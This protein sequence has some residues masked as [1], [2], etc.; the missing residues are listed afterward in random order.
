M[1]ESE[2]VAAIEGNGGSCRPSTLTAHLQVVER[3]IALMR[4]RLPEPLSL[5]DLAA[6]GIASPFHFNRIFRARTGVPP[7]QFLYALRL[8]EAKRL[9]LTSNRKVTDIC[10]DVGYNSLGSFTT[11]FTKLVG[12]PPT[13]FRRLR[14]A[15]IDLRMCLDQCTG[16]P[17]GMPDHWTV[18]GSIRGHG[19]RAGPVFVGLFPSAIPQGRPLACTV[20]M[21]PSFRLT[22][23]PA[24]R[25]WILAATLCLSPGP[26]A[27][28][29][30]DA[31]ARGRS[32]PVTVSARRGDL[33]ADVEL[34]PPRITDPPILAALPYL[35]LE[36]TARGNRD[37]ALTGPRSN[38][39]RAFGAASNGAPR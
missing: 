15:E 23:V 39:R 32:G 16:A 31:V 9:L 33:V 11:R 35:L 37:E 14:Q 29:Q 22:P 10:Y 18:V 12:V 21:H 1:T 36:Q 30:V 28:L 27:C 2:A 7:T 20:T 25:Y 24:G 4:Q 3:A 19:D 5:G 6:G 17:A 34:R 8:D 38:P 13:R 26:A